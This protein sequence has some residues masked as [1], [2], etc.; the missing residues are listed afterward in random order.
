MKTDDWAPIDPFADDAV[1][2]ALA[3]TRDEF[4]EQL[5]EMRWRLLPVLE[6]RHLSPDQALA[7]LSRIEQQLWAF[8]RVQAER[9]I[10]SARQQMVR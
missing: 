4:E 2:C 9:A 10:A 1:D 3:M 8:A 7:C 6:Q 5:N